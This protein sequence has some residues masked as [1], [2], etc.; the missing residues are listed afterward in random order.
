M[1]PKFQGA[2]NAKEMLLSC[3]FECQGALSASE[4]IRRRLERQR[5]LNA[6]VPWTPACLERQSASSAGQLRNPASIERR[7]T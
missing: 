4:P 7:R 6:S 5:A 3:V 1:G 2:T